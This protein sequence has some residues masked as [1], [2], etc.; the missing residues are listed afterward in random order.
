MRKRSCVHCGKKGHKKEKCWN[1][2]P[3]LCPKKN[4]GKGTLERGLNNTSIALGDIVSRLEGFFL[5]PRFNKIM[6]E[7]IETWL[8]DSV[9]S[10]H[11]TGLREVFLRFT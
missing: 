10:H 9:S 4:K 1:I 2:S 11:V 6:Y 8:V 3:H 7:D 5:M